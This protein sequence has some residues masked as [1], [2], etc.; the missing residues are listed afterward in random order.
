MRGRPRDARST[1]RSGFGRDRGPRGLSGG[2]LGGDRE[3]LGRNVANAQ[4]GYSNQ[5]HGK[6]NDELRALAPEIKAAVFEEAFDFRFVALLGIGVVAAF[7]MGMWG[8]DLPV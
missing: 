7:A 8:D 5:V 3:S 4:V 2:S 6:L 1:G